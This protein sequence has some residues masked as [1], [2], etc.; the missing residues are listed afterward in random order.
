MVACT[1]LNNDNAAAAAAVTP[2]VDNDNEPAPENCPVA[3][4]TVVG[5]DDIFSGWLHSGIC[6][7]RSTVC[8]DSKPELK[9]WMSSETEPTNLC[10][11]E[12]FF[13][14]DYIKKT[15]IPSTNKNLKGTDAIPVH[16]GE[17]LR[18]LVLWLLMLTMICPQ[19]HQFWAT[20]PIDAFKGT[21]LWLLDVA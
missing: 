16:Y 19:Y 7:H 10:L 2:M 18:W 14:K 21:P 8:Q 4:E 5:V 20:H 17:F 9:F 15:I 1:H 6:E 13:F 12:A 11:F 3:N